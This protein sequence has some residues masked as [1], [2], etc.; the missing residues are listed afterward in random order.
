MTIL[1]LQNV[2]LITGGAT[3][4]REVSS[5]VHQPGLTAIVGDNGSGKS[6]LLSLL[7]GQIAPTAGRVLLDGRMIQ[8]IAP[9]ERARQVAWLAQSTLGAESFAVRDVVGWGT[10]THSKSPKAQ[11]PIPHKVIEQ[12]G[13]GHLADAPLGSLSGGERQRAHLGRIWM[14]AAPI[15][16]LDEP[17]ARLDEAGRQLLRALIKDKVQLGHSVVIVTHDRAWAN[18]VA[19]HL[20]VVEAGRLAAQ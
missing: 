17:D 10:A 12:F 9:R 14:Q 4:V 13:L 6:S 3:R 1:E 7:A 19:D 18:N 11:A 5:T 15:T 2:T 16:L 20:W 8:E